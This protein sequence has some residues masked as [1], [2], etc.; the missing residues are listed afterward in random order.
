[1][2]WSD[3]E[4]VWKRQPLPV[5]A[6][7]DLAHLLAVQPVGGGQ[8]QAFTVTIQE[9]EGADLHTE[10]NGRPVDEGAHELVPVA[11]LGGQLGELV[12]EGE[13][14]ETRDARGERGLPG[15]SRRRG[16]LRAIGHESN[17]T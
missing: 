6:E 11:G 12:Q 17:P 14:V 3:Y 7:A 4:A 16:R 9:V 5:G 1:M 2:N 10:R 8:R 13:L 15:T